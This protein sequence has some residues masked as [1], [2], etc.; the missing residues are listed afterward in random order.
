MTSKQQY[1]SVQKMVYNKDSN[2]YS[3]GDA[4]II[5]LF[6]STSSLARSL[7]Q[8]SAASNMGKETFQDEEKKFNSNS[9]NLN[10]NI[11]NNY[12]QNNHKQKNSFSTSAKLIM[13]SN[14]NNNNKNMN[15]N[16]NNNSLMSNNTSLISNPGNNS[17]F[18]N[19]NFNH[20]KING[21]IMRDSINK[22]QSNP[23]KTMRNNIEI[24][25][26]THFY[27]K[28]ESHQETYDLLFY[29]KSDKRM[30]H[31]DRLDDFEVLKINFLNSLEDKIKRKFDMLHAKLKNSKTEME[32][33]IN[34]TDDELINLV[35]R[36]IEYMQIIHKNILNARDDDIA[37][38]AKIVEQYN[39]DSIITIDNYIKQLKKDLYDIG[40]VLDTEIEE[41]CREKALEKQKY[42]ESKK[43][44]CKI[45]FDQIKA[46]EQFLVDA[47][48]K[49]LQIFILRW[50]NVKL[51]RFIKDL[52]DVLHSKEFVDC[53][54]RYELIKNLKKDQEN[55]YKD[56]VNLV[57]NKMLNI[58]MEDVTVK[59][60]ESVNK[61]LDEIYNNAQNLFDMHTQK[62]MNNSELIYQK[63]IKEV[64]KF[65]DKI[66]KISYEFGKD[67]KDP[68][69]PHSSL[70]DRQINNNI[71]SEDAAVVSAEANANAPVQV[72]NQ[73][74]AK[75]E[76]LNSVNKK[77]LESPAA[78]KA[79]ASPVDKI[80][81]AIKS[82][83]SDSNSV[84]SPQSPEQ[85][86]QNNVNENKRKQNTDKYQFLQ[87]KYKPLNS[88]DELIEMEITPLVEK[89]KNERKNYI[90]K[91]I[92]YLDDYD[93]YI[94]NNCAKIVS[95]MLLIAG[96]NDSHRKNLAEKEK[97]FLLE[98]A[99]AA[100]HN[101][102]VI[103]EKEEILKKL[104]AE[105]KESFHKE[106]LDSKLEHSFN[107]INQLEIEYREYFGIMENL[108]NSHEGHMLEHFKFFEV[109][110]LNIFGLKTKDK[111][112][113]IQQRRSLESDFLS[114]RKEQEIQ[115]QEQREQEELKKQAAGKGSAAAQKK[116]AT[117]NPQ[118]LKKGELPPNLIPPR[119]I[120]VYKSNLG[121]EYLTDFTIPEWVRSILRNIIYNREDDILGINSIGTK[122][123][124]TNNTITN[125]M[126]STKSNF[127]NLINREN[128]ALSP[129]PDNNSNNA[130]APNAK[131]PGI[132]A[133]FSPSNTQNTN[134]LDAFNP[135][136][137]STIK[138][139]FS[140][141]S[142]SG[143][144]LLSE[145][146]KF[147]EE[148][149]IE[150][151]TGIFNGLV[152]LT[153]A[154]LKLRTENAK[155]TDNEKREELL[156]ELDIRLKSLA[157]RKGKIE[158]E[159][160]DKRL[161]EIEKHKEKFNQHIKLINDRNKKD[162][163]DCNS[164]IS[165]ISKEFEELNSLFEKLSKV[166]ED[167]SNL[168][169]LDDKFKKFKT[170]YYDLQTNLQEAELKMVQYTKANPE[171][172]INLNK[173]FLMSLQSYDKGGTYSDNELKFYYEQINSL[174]D[175]NIKKDML[176]RESLNQNKILQIKSNLATAYE[177]MEK[178]YQS[179]TENIQAKE[180]VGKK[181]GSPKRLA[182]DVIIN[183]KMKCNQAQEGL[184][185][186]YNKIS[187]LVKVYDENKTKQSYLLQE[188]IYI[189]IF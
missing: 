15:N 178:K 17:S 171:I 75:T 189:Y 62:L 103:F 65:K 93:E 140:P 84:I 4:S 7:R 18:L 116:K 166:M 177:K 50:K 11:G 38:S 99:K 126:N 105:M 78:A 106:D 159:E 186:L 185:N 187:D 81:S 152:E 175:E 170:S 59:A 26:L 39:Q 127:N 108:L 58:P 156:T 73:A 72:N 61:E 174:N 141:I 114:K 143:S 125:N 25:N 42:F 33:Q 8:Q 12:N 71:I 145:E 85:Q 124:N 34:K 181:F 67:N 188:Y 16:N 66:K 179:V 147:K 154:E 45:L 155:Q 63:S 36:D 161:N 30:R 60:I 110:I 86:N 165:G 55:I 22:V 77:S 37:N 68:D 158:V 13:D 89:F 53:S 149:L 136:E 46:D 176:E 163:D 40:F 144:K 146:N 64:E 98:M 43:Q 168:K 107:I 21:E 117:P 129:N 10:M 135:Y 115:L 41:I 142:E 29:L 102:D 56:R 120:E 49:N 132:N 91:I 69:I 150:I 23:P 131:E 83:M 160:Y 100:D 109:E 183:I 51:K 119:P 2:L 151:Y 14:F 20:E 88:I 19:I 79:S 139:F 28:I 5:G 157:P 87:D 123:I 47:C 164:L 48:K 113:E 101:D 54:E 148:F 130:K 32:N 180:S 96:K 112:E 44:E 74:N 1:R 122:A 169:S 153:S 121:H 9:N 182:N 97:K 128:T 184:D 90:T 31:L 82:P 104:S 133:E 35:L 57:I 92:S 134:F 95:T 118:K 173:N 80:A 172:L 27:D 94:N 76:N 52:K 167:E 111:L 6:K 24:R 138:E 3:N 162:N 70:N 137:V